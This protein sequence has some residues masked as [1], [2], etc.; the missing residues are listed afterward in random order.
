M[1]FMPLPKKRGDVYDWCTL[2]ERFIKENRIL[3]CDGIIVDRTPNGTTLKLANSQRRF[4]LR[5]ETNDGENLWDPETFTIMTRPEAHL[6]SDTDDAVGNIYMKAFE[7]PGDSKGD[8][9]L[10]A[11]DSVHIDAGDDIRIEAGSSSIAEITGGQSINVLADEDIQIAA[12]DDIY[13]KPHADGTGNLKIW[14]GS[15]WRD[16][17]TGSFTIPGP[18]SAND[19]F[20]QDGIIWAVNGV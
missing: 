5:S 13:L 11:E 15:V 20:V 9:F 8:I 19:V 17:W 4:A 10:E 12:N 3:P 18:P 7:S 14:D 1:E 6:D 2:A 16:G